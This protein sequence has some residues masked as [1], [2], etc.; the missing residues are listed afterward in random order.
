MQVCVEDT[1]SG[2]DQERL[3]DI[4]DPFTNLK[5]G[6]LG[7]GLSISGSIVEA[8]GGRIWAEN[9]SRGG[10]RIVFV[11]PAVEEES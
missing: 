11:L 1:G 2:I 5:S 4:F 6:G 7:M 3:E 8:H 10:A 9:R